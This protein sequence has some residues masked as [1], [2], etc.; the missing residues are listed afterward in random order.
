MSVLNITAEYKNGRTVITH[1]EFTAPIKIAAP[2]YRKDHTEIMM[3]TASAGIL[4]GD[5]YDINITVRENA[6]LRFTGQSYTKIF[7]ADKSGATQNVT[8]NVEKGGTLIYAPCPVIPFGGSI[9]DG[10]TN[11]YLHPESRFAMTDILASGRIAM[12]EEFAFTSYRS[13]TAVYIDGRLK[14]LDNRSLAPENTAL[15]SIGFFEGYTHTGSA[16]FYGADRSALDAMLPE[17]T[18]GEAAVS[19]AAAGI[20]VRAAGS[21]ADDMYRLFENMTRTLQAAP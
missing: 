9:F 11:V 2:F 17:Y 4:D 10:S 1:S 19:A 13:R 3:M 14:Y 15:D 6:A 12:D 8:I 20:S 21:G 7:R 5:S 18:S 16:Y